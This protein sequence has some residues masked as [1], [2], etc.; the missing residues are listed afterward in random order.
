[1]KIYI[2]E[3]EAHIMQ[4][5]LQIVNK[6]SAFQVVGHSGEVARAATE[7]PLLKPELILADIRLK[8]GDSF[9]LFNDIGMED[10]QVIFLTAYDQYAIQALN[11]GAFAY[12]LKPVDEVS[13]GEVLGKYLRHR[14]QEQFDKQQLEIARDHYLTQGIKGIKRIALKSLEYIEIVDL[15]DIIYCKS[16]KGYTTFCL[17]NKREVLVSKGLKEYENMLAFSGFLRCHQSYLINF[18]YVKKYYREGLLLME[19]GEKIPVSSRKKEEVY[20]YLQNI[21]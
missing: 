16:D 11:L 10:F 19:N 8:D 4:H 21:A 1:M 14:E 20:R 6:L 18:K 13:L 15:D 12:L 7:I 17:K 9:S 3:D 2:L 5:I